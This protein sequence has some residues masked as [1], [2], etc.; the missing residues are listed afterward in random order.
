MGDRCK[1]INKKMFKYVVR[2]MNVLGSQFLY[3][4]QESYNCKLCISDNSVVILSDSV[5]A[6]ALPKKVG[7]GGF[8]LTMQK[9]GIF[10]H[11]FF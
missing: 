4:V 9:I 10:F 7:P 3:V 1:V 2:L 11:T 8:L 6:Q 5:F